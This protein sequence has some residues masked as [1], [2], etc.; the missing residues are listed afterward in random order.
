MEVKQVNIWQRNGQLCTVHT[1]MWP[2][3][4]SN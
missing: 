4:T 3:P 2:T 1:A